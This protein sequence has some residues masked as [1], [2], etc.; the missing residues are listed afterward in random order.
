MGYV[1]LWKA[2]TRSNALPQVA[3]TRL[4]DP[5]CGDDTSSFDFIIGRP[6][7]SRPIGN[8]IGAHLADFSCMGRTV[9]WVH[10]AAPLREAAAVSAAYVHDGCKLTR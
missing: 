4:A 8:T 9:G 2:L 3:R 10:L 5:G 1:N 6:L 7:S